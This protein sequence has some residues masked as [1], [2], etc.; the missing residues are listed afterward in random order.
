MYISNKVLFILMFKFYF[1]YSILA[2]QTQWVAADELCSGKYIGI[3]L[4]NQAS[5]TL[6]NHTTTITY[7]NNR[8]YVSPPQVVAGITHYFGNLYYFI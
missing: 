3:N 8:V 7:P 1:I 5:N 2:Q 6:P 4:I